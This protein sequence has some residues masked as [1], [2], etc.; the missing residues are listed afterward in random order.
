VGVLPKPKKELKRLDY[1]IE[2]LDEAATA[3]RTP[4]CETD[5]GNGKRTGAVV[6]PR[7]RKGSEPCADRFG[8][9]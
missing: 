6:L 4:D 8:R 7:Q 5:G 1:Y 2:T 9:G 3:S